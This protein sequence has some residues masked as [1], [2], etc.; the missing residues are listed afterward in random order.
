MSALTNHSENLLLSWLFTTDSVTRPTTWYVALHVD[1]P[2]ETGTE[3]EL[4]TSEDA[5][6]VRKAIT[7]DTPS[8]GQSLSDSAVSW[9][10]NSGSAG[11]TVAYASIWDASTSGNCLMKGQL[12]VPRV[13]VA[14]GVLTFN[15]GEIIAILD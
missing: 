7:L 3:D 4:T 13:M 6:Y 11:Y 12:L 10:V 8:D 15:I 14:D 1:D 9:T 5:D 2:T